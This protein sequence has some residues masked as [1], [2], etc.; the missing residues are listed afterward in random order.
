MK[1]HLTEI[2]ELMT[3]LSAGETY[4]GSAEV[5]PVRDS[6]TKA[7]NCRRDGRLTS[8]VPLFDAQFRAF[9]CLK[10][11]LAEGKFKSYKELIVKGVCPVHAEPVH[12]YYL[13]HK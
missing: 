7:T 9:K 5:Q 13:S 11:P 2:D 3:I 1:R 4:T 12:L 10:K 8:A 6:Q